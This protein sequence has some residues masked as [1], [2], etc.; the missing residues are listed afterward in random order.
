MLIF[1]FLKFRILTSITLN[2]EKINYLHL[3]YREVKGI[4]CYR[5]FPR[6]ILPTKHPERSNGR[7]NPWLISQKSSCTQIYRLSR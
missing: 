7:G 3:L 6:P 5:E 1:F 4:L 2:I